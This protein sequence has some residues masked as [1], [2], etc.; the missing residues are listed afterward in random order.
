M[1]ACGGRVMLQTSVRFEC[2]VVSPL[3]RRYKTKSG[4]C[5]TCYGTGQ[6]IGPNCELPLLQMMLSPAEM[7]V[8]QQEELG[9]V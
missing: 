7:A 3:E 8:M 5:N 4:G 9:R 2:P 6:S 1:L